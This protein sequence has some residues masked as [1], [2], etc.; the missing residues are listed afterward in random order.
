MRVRILNSVLSAAALAL[1]L[2]CTPAL[3]SKPPHAQEQSQ[4][5]GKV[6]GEQGKSEKVNPRSGSPQPDAAARAG[7][8]AVRNDRDRDDDHDAGWRDDPRYRDRW[9]DND[10]DRDDRWRRDDRD[11]DHDRDDNNRSRYDDRDWQRHYSSSDARYY[12]Y[13]RRGYVVYRLPPRYQQVRFRGVP[14][15]LSEGSWYSP[16]NSGYRV[17]SPPVGL[18]LSFLPEVYQTLM[19]G[20]IPYYRANDVYYRWMPQDNAYMVSAFPGPY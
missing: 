17:V 6:K 15:Y 10:R 8:T 9:G 19:F 18:L 4:K 14:Y 20:S 12:S 7:F 11:N 5:H 1:A 13:P 16:Y 3:A 2:Q